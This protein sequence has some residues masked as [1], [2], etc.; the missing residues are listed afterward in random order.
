[1]LVNGPWTAVRGG[2]GLCPCRFVRNRWLFV[3]R[4]CVATSMDSLCGIDCCVVTGLKLLP[5]TPLLCVSSR[6]RVCVS[7][8][9]FWLK[10]SGLLVY[11][12]I[13]LEYEFGFEFSVGFEVV[14]VD[15]GLD[16]G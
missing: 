13:V 1:M 9:R 5:P 10:D 14:Y 3:W 16:Y 8:V 11:I 2:D 6:P 15:C 7:C 12:D 4:D